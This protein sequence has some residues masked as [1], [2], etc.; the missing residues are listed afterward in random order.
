MTL[1]LGVVAPNDLVLEVWPAW[2]SVV[3][4]AY[5]SS[6]P[7]VRSTLC[8]VRKAWRIQLLHVGSRNIRSGVRNKV[9]AVFLVMVSANRRG[10]W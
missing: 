5:V 6:R 10:L 2:F 1:R 4:Y 3:S 9:G 7:L 8:L